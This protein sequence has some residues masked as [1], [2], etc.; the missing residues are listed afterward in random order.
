MP[1]DNQEAPASQD[2]KDQS[3]FKEDLALT[4]SL[5]HKDLQAHQE[6]QDLQGL[7]VK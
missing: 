7:Q 4:V 5:A 2:R 1:Q 6:L 3:A